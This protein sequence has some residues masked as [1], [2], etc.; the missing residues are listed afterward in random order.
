MTDL[1]QRLEG[2]CEGFERAAAPIGIEEVSEERV[3]GEAVYVVQPRL[4]V[5]RPLPGWAVAVIAAFVVIVVASAAFLLARGPGVAPFAG[6]DT[7]LPGSA[8]ILLEA[9]SGLDAASVLIGDDW[10][11]GGY[12][13]RLGDGTWVV[14]D[15]ARSGDTVVW[16]LDEGTGEWAPHGVT[17]F[18]GASV[19]WNRRYVHVGLLWA[20]IGGTSPPEVWNSPDGVTWRHVEW[21]GT[22]PSPEQ[23]PPF[24]LWHYARAGDT[25][26]MGGQD[27]GILYVSSDVGRRFTAIT[28]SPGTILHLWHTGEEFRA[29]VASTRPA[30]ALTLWRSGD[31]MRW[32]D[33]G[34]V[35]GLEDADLRISALSVS[36]DALLIGEL[37]IGWLADSSCGGDVYRSTDGGATWQALGIFEWLTEGFPAFLNPSCLSVASAD[38]EWMLVTAGGG[39]GVPRAGVWG[40]RNGLDWYRLRGTLLA[41]GGS[42]PVIDDGVP[43]PSEP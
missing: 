3:G 4:R 26:L 1:R 6:E 32:E 17:E 39:W 31:G 10:S 18:G 16:A 9:G 34:R 43:P 23:S 2:F 14:L 20:W 36:P 35:S 12:P 13:E 40:S 11:Y 25:I 15:N 27:D 28:P 41:E 21:R 33:M 29:I 38:G 19:P 30:D 7:I 42:Y 22:P 37:G 8:P 5:G 24:A